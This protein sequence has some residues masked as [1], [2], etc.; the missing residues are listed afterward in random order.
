MYVWDHTCIRAF[1]PIIGVESICLLVKSKSQ[2]W[3]L[4]QLPWSLWVWH[5][6]VSGWLLGF[7]KC[8]GQAGPLG[9]VQFPYLGW[10]KN[11][12]S[13]YSLLKIDA[14]GLCFLSTQPLKADQQE[15]E[16]SSCS[17]LSGFNC[18]S[19]IIL[20]RD[21]HFH[22]DLFLKPGNNGYISNSRTQAMGCP[23]LRYWALLVAHI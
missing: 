13:I 3:E 7:G 19:W 12:E 15:E 14:Y 5:S 1:C 17:P 16:L 22:S 21:A 11:R 9:L 6:V 20:L 4:P 18:H 10:F 23:L 8:L 2:P